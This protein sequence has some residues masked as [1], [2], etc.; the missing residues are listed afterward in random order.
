MLRI[1]SCW[2]VSNHARWTGFQPDQ[3]FH[4]RSAPNPCTSWSWTQVERL[5]PEGVQWTMPLRQLKFTLAES[6]TDDGLID[7]CA[8]FGKTLTWL[9]MCIDTR[10]VTARSVAV[11]CMHAQ[12]HATLRAVAYYHLRQGCYVC[13]RAPLVCHQLNHECPMHRS[14]A[15]MRQRLTLLQTLD[16]RQIDELNGFDL[17]HGLKI[18]ATLPALQVDPGTLNPNLH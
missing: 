11:S 10:A 6:L 14:C 15:A 16:M 18:L 12:V 5:I 3:W 9:D 7:I 4:I 1:Y 8:A 17:G 13:Y 2:L